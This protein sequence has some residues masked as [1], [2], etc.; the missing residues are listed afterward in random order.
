MAT[1]DVVENPMRHWEGRLLKIRRLLFLP[2]NKND[3]FRGIRQATHGRTTDNAMIRAIIF[4]FGRVISAPRPADRFREYESELGIADGSINRIMFDSPA[5]QD[6]LVG[7]LTMP[8]F[9]AAI[10]PALGLTTPG[11]IDTFRCRYYRDE[12][13]NMAVLRLIRR[14]H[15]NY[16]LAVLSNHPPGL[17]RWLRDWGLRDLFDVVYCSGDEGRAKPDAAVYLATLD[18]L[19]VRPI[20]AAFIDDTEGHV[21]VARALGIHGIVFSDAKRLERELEFL[22]KQDSPVD[23]FP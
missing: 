1:P 3:R 7:R 5:W 2:K 4:D 12:S 19:G 17:D 23:P 13:V 9:W 16:R 11:E 10:G 22:L 20:E 8:G 6:A 21:T 14:L 15:G 18:R